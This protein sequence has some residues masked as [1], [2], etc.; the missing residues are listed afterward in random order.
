MEQK[1]EYKSIEKINIQQ[2]DRRGVVYLDT[3]LIDARAT[4][5]Q[6]RWSIVNDQLCFADEH[7]VKVSFY[8][9]VGAVQ[10]FCFNTGRGPGEM[11]FPPLAFFSLSGGDYFYSDKNQN[12]F[13]VSSDFEVKKKINLISATFPKNQTKEYLNNLLLK[14]DPTVY[15]MYEACIQGQ[16]YVE[17]TGKILFPVTTEHIKFNG[18]L[19]QYAAEFYKSAFNVMAIDTTEMEVEHLFCRYPPVYD[20]SCIPNFKGCHLATDG[21]YLYVNFEADYRIYIYNNQFEPVGW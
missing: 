16:D 12:M 11:L 3:L 21:E 18:I 14:P 4:S 19:E 10:R 2:L 13:I 15:H 1:Y 9:T 6:G 7:I 17:Y 20:K 8:D 5:L